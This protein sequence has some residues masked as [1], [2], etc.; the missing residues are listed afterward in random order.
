MNYYLKAQSEILSD[1]EVI[2]R[3]TS[4]YRWTDLEM[5]HAI[6]RALREWHNRVGIEWYYSLSGGWVDGT[7]SYSMPS[8]VEEPVIPQVLH[9]IREI[10]GVTLSSNSTTWIDLPGGVLEPNGTGGQNLRLDAEPASIDGRV[11]F[12]IRNGPI[13]TAAT[14]PDLDAAINATDTSVTLTGVFELPKAGWVK[15]EQEWIFYAGVTKSAT[16]TTL[17]NCLRA[18]Y[19][20]TA[21][22]HAKDTL[23]AWG[24]AVHTMSLYNALEYAV[25]KRLHEMFITNGAATEINRH[26]AMISYYAGEE[27]KFWKAYRNPM[28]SRMTVAYQTQFD[29]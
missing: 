1:S 25:Y 4:N 21:A 13:P 28:R 17:S 27:Q 18:Q 3:D 8:Y 9:Y 16:V 22:T 20:T 19:G 5:Y 2:M 12:Y 14:L 24:I 29:R 6:N 26:Q 7:W 23:V 11:L 10:D 15:I